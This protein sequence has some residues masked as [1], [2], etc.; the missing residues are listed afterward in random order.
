V[1]PDVC[2]H[3]AG[4]AAIGA[5]RANPRGTWEVNLH[6]TL[7]VA[8]A[9]LAA[10]PQCRMIFISS[11][12]CYGASF[13]SGLALDEFA[14]LAP[15]N[16]YA[17]TKAATEL[18]L[19][20]LAAEGLRLM[21]L[22]P[23]NHTG[24]GQTDHF[25]VPAFAGQIA[26][27]EAGQMPAEMA[28]GALDPERD[29]LDVRDVCSAY[30]ASIDSFDDVENNTVIN[31]ASGHAVKIGT[32]LDLLLAQAKRPIAVRQDQSR[33]RPVEIRRAIGDATRAKTLLN[34]QPKFELRQTLD[35]VLNFARQQNL[36]S[37]E[38]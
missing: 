4:V 20:V 28:V 31:I 33:L 37:H 38:A 24:P 8:D 9:I 1:R 17:A 10:A 19:G 23:F 29:F 7:N 15:M 21:R 36:A 32:I 35:A 30:V 26:R 5:A 6:G 3:L 13:K 11:A 16:L 18:A 2:V 14:N 22:R 34:W 27:I 12:E 25:V